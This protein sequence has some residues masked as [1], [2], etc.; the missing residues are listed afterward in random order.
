MGYKVRFVEP[1]THYRSIKKEVDSTFQDVLAKGD[2]IYR[3]QLKS[4]EDHL[5]DFV[6]TKHAVGLNSGFH[7]LHLSVI[8]AGI[9]PGD[10]V[11]VPAHTFV[12]AVSAIV[13]TGAKPILVDVGKDYNL[14]MSAVERAVTPR[15]TA[16]MPTHLNGRVCDMERM[17]SIAE[18]HDLVIIED[19]AQALGATFKGKQAGSFGLTGC[20][21]FYPFKVLGA[22]GDAGA[23]TTDNDE[24]AIKI[25]R[26]RYIGEDR[27]TREYHY[28]GFT[29]LLD[30]LQAAI[31]DVKLRHLP[32]WLKRRRQVAEIYVR[33]LSGIGDL[34]LPNFDGD[35]YHDN[36]QNFVVR[37]RKRDQ[38][39]KYLKD[40]GVEVLIS[41]PKPM[42]KHGGLGLGMQDLPE[43]E[44][45]C[46]EVISLPM[47]AEISDEN[48]G[49]VIEMIRQFYA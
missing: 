18:E 8:A 35:Q 41:W 6:G 9:G 12:A 30:N 42:W 3:S 17:M 15:T 40:K 43:T 13:H 24:V 36:F 44:A 32:E 10:E 27:E 5:A 14:D 23:V 11:I 1:D 46:R 2:L 45:I 39:A 34:T 48:V 19:A 7:A 21:S 16:V 28:H 4:F 26:L 31:L 22:F 37:T 38:L 20:F 29:C 33:G 25:A 49:Y 47:N